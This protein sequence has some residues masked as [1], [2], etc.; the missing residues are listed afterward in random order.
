MSHRA[1]LPRARLVTTWWRRAG[2]SAGIVLGLILGA[3]IAA[4]L[5][6]LP[7]PLILGPAPWN[8]TRRDAHLA[9]A[10]I[11]SCRGNL[12]GTEFRTNAAGLRGPEIRDDASIRILALGDSCTWGWRVDDAEAYP[13]LLQRGLDREAGSG[14]FQVLNAGA[15]GYTSLQGLRFLVERG[16]ALR[17]QIIIA[18]F[19]WNDAARGRD[20]AEELA[21][22]TPPRFVLASHEF[23]LGHS[24]VYRWLQALAA[25]DG[26]AAAGWRGT[27]RVPPERYQQNLLRIAEQARGL[28]ARLVLV[29]WNAQSAAEHRARLL[30][31]AHDVDVPVVTYDGPRFDSIHPTPAGHAAFADRVLGALIHARL[32]EVDGPAGATPRDVARGHGLD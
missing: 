32:V 7:S 15:P 10:F 9:Y 25:D 2:A 30:R 11:P 6:R 13:A 26:P 18:G 16:G 12:S 5:L 29:D 28:G 4:R 24:H 27:Q 3:E 20:T 17:P 19:L 14:R 21:A 23:L 8:C 22:P 1:A 31:V